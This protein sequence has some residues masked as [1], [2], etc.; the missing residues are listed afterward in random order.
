MWVEAGGEGSHVYLGHR[1]R[2]RE[3]RYTGTD[4]VGKDPRE[5]GRPRQVRNRTRSLGTYEVGGNGEFGVGK[6]QWGCG[7]WPVGLPD[8]RVCGGAGVC[9]RVGRT[10]NV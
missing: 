9:V 7:R 4:E 5:V 8:S 2:V 10:G 6:R 1:R 3:D